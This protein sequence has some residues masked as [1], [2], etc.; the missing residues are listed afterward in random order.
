MAIIFFYPELHSL[1]K[2]QSVPVL[3]PSFNQSSNVTNAIN[4]S[5]KKKWHVLGSVE[6]LELRVLFMCQF[7][8]GFMLWKTSVGKSPAIMF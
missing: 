7:S 8:V 2:F 3:F 1:N 4:N 6:S 5:K